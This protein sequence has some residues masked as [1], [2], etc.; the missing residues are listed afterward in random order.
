MAEDTRARK[1][2]LENYEA[3]C[4]SLDGMGWKYTK[5][6]DELMVRVGV[7][8]DDLPMDFIIKIDEGRQLIRVMSFLPFKFS[9]E[10]IVDGS[11]ATSQLNN[12]LADGSF[13]FDVSDGTVLF[14]MTASYK[15]SL[16]SQQ[17]FLH[18]IEYSCFVVDKYNDKL[19]MLAKGMMDIKDFFLQLAD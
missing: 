10:S 2:A 3:L 5:E 14:R 9:G 12:L 6:E 19:M 16:I 1:S 8:G 17:L 13:D 7:N 15:D 4:N 18:M 11:L